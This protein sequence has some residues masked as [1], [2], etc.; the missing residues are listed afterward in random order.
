MLSP[1]LHSTIQSYATKISD[2][3]QYILPLLFPSTQELKGQQEL[4]RED[5]TLG[6]QE[7]HVQRGQLR[8]A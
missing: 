4:S 5:G 3:P 8:L 7:H 2:F 1:I 6:N